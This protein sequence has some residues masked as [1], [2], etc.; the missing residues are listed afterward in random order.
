MGRHTHSGYTEHLIPSTQIPP[1][2]SSMAEYYGMNNLARP[3][4]SLFSLFMGCPLP[5]ILFP[6][7]L[8]TYSPS[9]V[10]KWTRT[11][12]RGI[13]PS[14][15]LPRLSSFVSL[16]AVGYYISMLSLRASYSWKWTTL[17]FLFLTW[18]TKE[19]FPPTLSSSYR[20]L[21]TLQLAIWCSQHSTRFDFMH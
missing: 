13:P 6:P 5:G 19:V 2:S 8:H 14:L 1:P 17:S 12:I 11:K 15:C 3:C 10:L 7:F 16:M 20:M 21:R 18:T 4:I 9:Y